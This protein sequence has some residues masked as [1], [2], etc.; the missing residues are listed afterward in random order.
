VEEKVFIPDEPLIVMHR[1]F[2][3]EHDTSDD[4]F[5]C[6]CRPVVGSALIEESLIPE[7]EKCDG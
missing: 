4:P 1:D 2:P 3:G 7:A 6:W 5:R